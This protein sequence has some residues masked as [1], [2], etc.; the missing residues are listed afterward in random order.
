[1]PLNDL[2]VDAFKYYFTSEKNNFYFTPRQKAKN[3]IKNIYV[4]K[5]YRTELTSFLGVKKYHR[6]GYLKIT[7]YNGSWT[8]LPVIL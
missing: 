8:E 5:K 7:A 2:I 4:I 1:M 6:Y 3:I